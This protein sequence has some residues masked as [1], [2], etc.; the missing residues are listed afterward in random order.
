MSVISLYTAREA[1]LRHVAADPP[2]V[3][4]LIAPEDHATYEDARRV[5]GGADH[6]LALAGDEGVETSLDK[7]WHGVHW[8]LGGAPPLDFLLHGG[9]TLDRIDGR[10]RLLDAE[11]V[12]RI[13]DALVRVPDE[14]LRARFDPAAMT[15]ARVYPPIWDRDTPDDDDLQWLLDTA[16]DLRAGVRAAA[17]S[18]LG[19]IVVIT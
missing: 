13:H 18:G 12:A 14:A 4:K 16:A 9:R 6:A 10:P 1:T 15:A 2:L 11:Q 17:E 3:W 5:H 8:L 19:L 7:G